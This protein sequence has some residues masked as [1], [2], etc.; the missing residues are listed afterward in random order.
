MYMIQQWKEHK[1]QTAYICHELHSVSSY[2]DHLYK[3]QLVDFLKSKEQRLYRFQVFNSIKG[4][5]GAEGAVLANFL[6]NWAKL[7]NKNYLK[8]GTK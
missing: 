1:E 7:R 8:F 6:K 4:K 3:D 5:N 2:K